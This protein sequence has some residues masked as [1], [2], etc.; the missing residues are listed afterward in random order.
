MGVPLD[1]RPWST[2]HILR[3][4]PKMARVMEVVD[5]AWLQHLEQN[6][7]IMPATLLSMSQ[8]ELSELAKNHSA[9]LWVDISQ[10]SDRKP[11]V[12]GRRRCATTNTCWYSYSLDRGML[13]IEYFL[14]QG[15][16]SDLNLST[17]KFHEVQS[18]TGD[19]FA[20]PSCAS[21]L[22]ALLLSV[23]SGVFQNEPQL[24]QPPQ[25]PHV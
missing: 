15:H 8:Q 3:G 10:M 25:G 18:L 1:F 24:P 19:A 13:D 4:I 22:L 11:W 6:H 14:S 12:Y 17:L 16:D 23:K 7:N 2:A 5:L 9:E 21:I 20:L